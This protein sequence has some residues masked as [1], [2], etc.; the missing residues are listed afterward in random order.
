M[1]TGPPLRLARPYYHRERESWL[2]QMLHQYLKAETEYVEVDG[3]GVIID[4]KYGQ[5]FFSMACTP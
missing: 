5:N 3:I 1:F 2:V 4:L